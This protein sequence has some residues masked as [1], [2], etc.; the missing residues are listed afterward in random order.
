MNLLTSSSPEGHDLSDKKSDLR[1]CDA[2]T[3]RFGGTC[4][5]NGADIKCVCQFHCNKK[6]VPV[7]GSNGDTYQNE[8]FLRRAACKKQR[9]ISIMEVLVLQMET[10]KVLV[11][12]KKP[13]NVKT[14]SLEPNVTK[15]LRTCCEFPLSCVR[16]A[17][18]LD[19][20]KR[21]MCNIVC[22]GHNDNPVCGSDGLTY[23]TPCHVREASCL[24]QLKIDIK[25]VGRCQGNGLQNTREED[26]GRR[27]DKSRK[28]DG[29]KGKPDIYS[30]SKPEEGNGFLDGALPCAEDDAQTCQHG[31]CEMR[32]NLPTCR[33]DAAYGGPRCDQLL[34][35]NILYV[36]PSG[37]K[38]HYVLIAAI[39]GAVQIA[40]IVAVVM[41]FTRRC[42]K[43]KRGRR[44]KQHLGHFP[45]GTSSRMIP[46][47]P[48]VFYCLHPAG[49]AVYLD[50]TVIGANG[51]L[52]YDAIPEMDVDVFV[53]LD[54]QRI[55]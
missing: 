51:A 28:D 35:F 10:M 45:S 37:Q 4:R 17:A 6:Y 21:C 50:S 2:G 30:A 47:V 13:P 36:V 12:G 54:E 3:C 42:N 26:D 20:L 39:I 27:K 33:C 34:D 29:S 44:Q 11:E 32:H 16:S 46:A 9:A 1:V 14:A 40:V 18:I 48:E 8:C 25:H 49:G 41:C 55:I 31:H 23:D 43:S 24:K 19:S 5:E 22:N 15:T 7:C 53:R 52:C 38:L